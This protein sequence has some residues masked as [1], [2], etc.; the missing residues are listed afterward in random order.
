ML[1]MMIFHYVMMIECYDDI[2][3]FVTSND[4]FGDIVHG[5]MML[6]S[7]GMMILCHYK[8]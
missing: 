4:S 2:A 1:I 6:L 3:Q 7:Y 5:V 8:R